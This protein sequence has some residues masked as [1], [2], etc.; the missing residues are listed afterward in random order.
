MEGVAS[1]QITMLTANLLLKSIN[2]GRKEFDRTAT[3]RADHMVMAAPV[4]LVLITRDAIVEGYFTREPTFGEQLESPI[5]RSESNARVFLLHKAVQFIRREVLA[6]FQKGSQNRV[7][8]RRLFQSHSL[9]MAM[10]DGLRLEY[11]LARDAGLIVNSFLQ[12]GF[13]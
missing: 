13:R 5:H 10:E 11:H 6:R 9:E 12:H 3:L 8:L 2:F 1:R 7:P 4:V